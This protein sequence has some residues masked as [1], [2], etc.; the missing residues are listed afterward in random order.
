M[1]LN[2]NDVVTLKNA[3]LDRGLELGAQGVIV[4]VFDE[5]ALAY[6]VEFSDSFGRTITT[7][8]LPPEELSK[9]ME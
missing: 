2:I 5:P 3:L 4:Q 7:I 1:K 6:E 8:A 9:R